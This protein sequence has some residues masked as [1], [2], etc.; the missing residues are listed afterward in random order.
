DLDDAMAGAPVRVV[1]DRDVNEV[2][3]EVEQELAQIEVD[4]EDEGIVVKADT[5]G[6]LEAIASALKE[7][8]IPILRAE[9]GDVAP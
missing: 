5:L 8:E 1:R 7:A 3:A 6:S 9:V 2:I 4:T